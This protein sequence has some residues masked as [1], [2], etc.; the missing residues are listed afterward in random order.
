MTESVDA[1]SKRP[2]ATRRAWKDLA[3]HYKKIREV[4]LRQLFH[5]DPQRGDR[6]AVEAV[7][8]YFDY[9]KNRITDETLTL[10]FRLA[11]ESHLQDRIDAMFRGDK[12]NVTE[13]RA[14]LHIALRAPREESIFVVVSYTHLRRSCERITRKRARQAEPPAPPLKMPD[15]LWWRRRFRLR[16][17]C[18]LYTSRCV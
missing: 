3:A 13:K 7:G 1:A 12:I 5:D 6:F 2:V 4:H 14:V 11:R 16:S 18:L 8:L 9:S 17:C 15:L 10:L